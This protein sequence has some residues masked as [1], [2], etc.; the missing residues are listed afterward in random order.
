MKRKMVIKR[1]VKKRD[2]LQESRNDTEEVEQEKRIRADSFGERS[3]DAPRSER[4]EGAQGDDKDVH[5]N[6]EGD[7]DEE[8][9]IDEEIEVEEEVEQEP[10]ETSERQTSS[11][12][13]TIASSSKLSFNVVC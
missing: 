4:R 3:E 10:T 1:R 7:S 8:V 5:I 6:D 12:D 11:S 13:T 9:E 2:L